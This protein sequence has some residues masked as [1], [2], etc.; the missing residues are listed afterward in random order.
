MR[1]RR[2]RRAR[3]AGLTL[4]E[5]LVALSV[6]ALVLLALAGSF[7]SLI[8]VETRTIASTRRLREAEGLLDRLIRSLRSTLPR[9]TFQGSPE[10][11]EIVTAALS[12]EGPVRLRIDRVQEGVRY[13]EA[14]PPEGAI[15]DMPLPGVDHVHFRFRDAAG[16]W[17][18]TWS[19]SMPPPSVSIDLSVGGE[20]YGTIVSIPVALR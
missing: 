14:F 17:R 13:G 5:V 3:E 19:D 11:I 6:G 7:R 18:E 9:E 4:V 8:R 16:N 20:T 12:R 2:A 10:G 15:E 1:R